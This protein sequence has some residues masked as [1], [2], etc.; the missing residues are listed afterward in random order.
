MFPPFA[1][2]ESDLGASAWRGRPAM[3]YLSSA[4]KDLDGNGRIVM[5]NGDSVNYRTAR[6]PRLQKFCVDYNTWR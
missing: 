5:A 6:P 4:S 3:N 2:T 1:R